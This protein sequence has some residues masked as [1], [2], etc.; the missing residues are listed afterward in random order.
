MA[1]NALKRI[2]EDGIQSGEIPQIDDLKTQMA[3]LAEEDKTEVIKIIEVAME[4]ATEE[5]KVALQ[6]LKNSIEVWPVEADYS[7]EG[8]GKLNDSEIFSLFFEADSLK[9]LFPKWVSTQIGDMPHMKNAQ[10]TIEVTIWKHIIDKI[11]VWG[12]AGSITN[13]IWWAFTDKIQSVQSAFSDQWEENSEDGAIEGFWKI[14]SVIENIKKAFEDG[15]E[16]SMDDLGGLIKFIEFTTDDYYENLAEIDTLISK[17]WLSESEAAS[18]VSNP[19]II[20]ALTQTWKYEGN[21]FK[22]NLKDEI[23]EL[24]E[25]NNNPEWLQEEFIKEVWALTSEKWETIDR[26]KKKVN[27]IAISLDKIWFDKASLISFWASLAKIPVLWA[28][29]KSLFDYVMWDGSIFEKL[30]EIGLEKSI[31]DSLENLNKF[32]KEPEDK[33]DLPWLV[34]E[35][36]NGKVWTED[37]KLATVFLKEVSNTEEKQGIEDTSV[38]SSTFWTEVFQKED[39]ADISPIMIQIRLATSHLR[40]ST[41]LSQDDFFTALKEVKIVMPIENNNED[42]EEI[43]EDNAITNT[44]PVSTD[45]TQEDSLSVAPILAA[46]AWVLAASTWTDEISSLD[47]TTEVTDAEI[48]T[49]PVSPEVDETVEVVSLEDQIANLVSLPG[50]LKMED[51]EE[52]RINI[53]GDKKSIEIND[54]IYSISMIADSLLGDMPIF[55]E[56]SF[57]SGLQIEHL[58]SLRE[59]NVETMD[60]KKLA[61]I[62][63][64]IVE[65]WSF[66]EVKIE[67]GKEVKIE[68]KKTWSKVS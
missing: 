35:W 15:E 62:M 24:W 38:D 23:L 68:I 4:N 64:S 44:P 16:P 41:K 57:D 40:W 66:D 30:D 21:W 17:K 2:V 7:M 48:P 1:L 65:N 10:T 51:G 54:D 63:L 59:T 56:V 14:A 8:I 45:Q 61:E 49:T 33:D 60:S 43:V 37:R 5:A 39:P 46:G 6:D 25:A 53:W 47:S 67:G 20:S 36:E 32:S 12:V 52:L 22:I 31:Q 50:V 55:K 58:T 27:A 29:L 13:I 11:S 28:F 34:S 3:G 26:L 42:S 9:I 18:I 19:Y